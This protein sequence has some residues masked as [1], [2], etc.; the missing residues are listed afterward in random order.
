[1]IRD[2]NRATDVIVRLRALFSRKP[3]SIE[4]LD[5]NEVAGEVLALTL[6]DLQR[7]RIAAPR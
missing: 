2:A 7:S 5:I 4:P 3:P 1:M 6:S